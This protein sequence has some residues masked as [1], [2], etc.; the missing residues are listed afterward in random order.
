MKDTLIFTLLLSSLVAVAQPKTPNDAETLEK[1]K[2]KIE[3]M[4]VAYLTNELELTVEESQAFWPVYNELQDKEIE[5]RSNQLKT[6]K[7]L[8]DDV[9][10]DEAIEK[11]I[12]SMADAGINIAELRKSYLDDFIKVI[13]AN[14]TAQLMR[15]EKEF[16]RRMMVRMKGGKGPHERGRKNGERPIR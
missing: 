8:E 2:E 15:A 7:N 16:G 9:M 11:M 3:A 4:K 6:F 12:Y 1:K 5:L 14:K 10:S 13:G